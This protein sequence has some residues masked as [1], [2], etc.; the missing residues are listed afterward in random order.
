MEV[1]QLLLLKHMFKIQSVYLHA[2]ML[3]W[4]MDK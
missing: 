3:S 1:A 2:A 4:N